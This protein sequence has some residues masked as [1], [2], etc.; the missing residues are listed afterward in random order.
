MH[1]VQEAGKCRTGS[2]D[3]WGYDCRDAGRRKTGK[4]EIERTKNKP[5]AVKTFEKIEEEFNRT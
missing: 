3:G 4:T 2:Y 1:M 5:E